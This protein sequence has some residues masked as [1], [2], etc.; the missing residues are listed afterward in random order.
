MEAS[1]YRKRRDAICDNFTMCSDDCPLFHHQNAK[2]IH[3]CGTMC[4]LLFQ[5]DGDTCE[6]LIIK[7]ERGRG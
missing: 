3:A 7:W 2:G 5:T 4:D 6:K 1:E